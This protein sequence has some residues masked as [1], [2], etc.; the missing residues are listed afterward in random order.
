M[1]SVYTPTA[2]PLGSITLPQ[3]NTDYVSAASVNVPLQALAD[4]VKCIGQW[5]VAADI[6]SLF[7]DASGPVGATCETLSYTEAAE[8]ASI[9]CSGANA[10]IKAGDKL[11]VDMRCH[12]VV[13]AAQA[14]GSAMLTGRTTTSGGVQV[15]PLG[16]LQA[17]TE[18]DNFKDSSGKHIPI[19]MTG[20][21]EIDDIV[22]VGADYVKLGL[23]GKVSA[24]GGVLRLNKPVWARVQVWRSL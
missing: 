3:D 10:V 8:Y 14:I 21:I 5:Y 19:A 1:S 11:I 9:P 23:Y 18:I 4:G 13:T 2:V 6:Y 12:A 7:S 24:L 20:V 22:L 17:V 15:Y 16:V